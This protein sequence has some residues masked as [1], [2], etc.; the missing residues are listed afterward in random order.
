M[1]PLTKTEK[2][3]MKP[4]INN[5]YPIDDNIANR[6]SGRAFAAKLVE[7]EVL[8]SLFEAARWAPSAFNEQPWRF[9][10]GIK[11]DSNFVKI[12]DVLD[13]FN[14]KWALNAPVLIQVLAKKSFTQNGKANTHYMHDVGQAMANLSIEATRHNLNVHQMAGFD[15]QKA[16]EYFINS[17]DFAPVTVVAVG[18]R[19]SADQLPDNLKDREFAPQ[20]RKPLAELVTFSD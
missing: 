7:D 13:P 18:Y 19:G 2:K 4:K 14:Q 10:V 9:V 6:W 12:G 15:K 5:E 11:G 3:N 16:A 17:D 20:V 1:M 8:M